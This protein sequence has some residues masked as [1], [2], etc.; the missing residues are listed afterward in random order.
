MSSKANK[1]N[2]DKKPT[3]SL[4]L[5]YRYF[6]IYIQCSYCGDLLKVNPERKYFCKQCNYTFTEKEIR[7]KC[8]L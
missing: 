7:E 5:N 6:R 1:N 4:N 8:G 2:Q 3:D